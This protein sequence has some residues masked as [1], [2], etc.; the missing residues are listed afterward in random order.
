MKRTIIPAIIMLV[1]VAMTAGAQ[2]SEGR[3][4]FGG[5]PYFTVRFLP[6]V[7]AL[8]DY[9]A[10]VG[11]Y[12]A[13]GSLL[14]PFVDGGGGTW[15]LR[16]SRTLQMGIDYYGAGYTSLGFL[17]HE[18]DPEAAND[19]VD[20]DGDGLDDYYSYASYGFSFVAGLLA[21]EVPLGS[22]SLAAT[23]TG[24]AGLGSE[25]FSIERNPRTVLETGLEIVAGSSDWTRR[26]A[27]FGG[28]VGIAWRPNP[29]GPFSLGL[30]VGFDY[31]LPMGDWRPAPGVHRATV[32]PPADFN[33]MNAWL[34]VGPRF[35][36]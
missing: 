19:T 29:R 20:E 36:Y 1:I 26:L 17:T 18:T 12:E 25:G 34:F 27:L 6:G 14:Y 9:L 10:S 24:R 7:D 22:R 21:T 32:A 4:R 13:L 3:G 5:S 8:D 31:Y 35:N 30:D 15:R 23:F 33:A 16:L 11:D 2:Q 28:S